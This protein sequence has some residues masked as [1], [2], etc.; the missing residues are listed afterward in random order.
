[1]IWDLAH[2]SRGESECTP[3][4]VEAPDSWAAVEKLRAEIP[5]DHLVLYV[6]RT[7]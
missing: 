5:G 4:A 1:M 6:R 7:S 3:A 2:R